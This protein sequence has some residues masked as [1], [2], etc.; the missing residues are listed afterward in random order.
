MNL[1]S[2]KRIG[3][4]G[5]HTDRHQPPGARRHDRGKGREHGEDD[6]RARAGRRGEHELLRLRPVRQGAQHLRP[7]P[8][9]GDRRAP[10][11]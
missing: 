7:Q 10:R 2:A 4:A 9:P 6:E 1:F 3:A 8:C 5:W 11:H